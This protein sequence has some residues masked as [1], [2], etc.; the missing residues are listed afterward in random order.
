MKKNDLSEPTLIDVFN[1]FFRSGFP[2]MIGDKATAVGL[3]IIFKWNSLM[4][5]A[6]FRMANSELESLSG[7]D[8]HLGRTRQKILDDC[9]IGGVPLFTYVSNGTR[10]AGTYRINTNLLPNYDQIMTKLTPNYGHNGN[11]LRDQRSEKE[12]ENDHDRSSSENENEE[13][14]ILTGT[15][16]SDHTIILGAI[17][18]KWGSQIIHQPP[19]AQ[20][21]AALQEHARET[22]LE[23]IERAPL[24]LKEPDRMKLV[25]FIIAVA[26]HPM[27]YLDKADVLEIQTE[28]AK[29]R[30][31]EKRLVE[32]CET[33]LRSALRDGA[34]SEIYGYI[35]FLARHKG[36]EELTTF[37]TYCPSLTKPLDY[38]QSIWDD[39]GS[40]AYE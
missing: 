32:K 14:E 22:L 35:R 16:A 9:K 23:A 38:Y 39:P 20:V 15:T 25:G 6:D 28:E 24:V 36:E 18:R 37:G 21:T 2:S 3:A 13:K 11:D 10:R 27:W 17:M 31:K 7:C 12:T 1:F 40:D 30:A 34:E 26:E 33:S 5:P 8:S 4:R 29:E 19:F